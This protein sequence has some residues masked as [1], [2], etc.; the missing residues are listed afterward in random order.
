MKRFL[1]IFLVCLMLLP[2]LSAC[3]GKENGN[4]TNETATTPE[5]DNATTVAETETEIPEDLY[6][7][8][9]DMTALDY[10][11]A[12]VRILQIT[13]KSDE[14][15]FNQG[16]S[17]TMANA[18]YSRNKL[19]E[20]ELGIRFEYVSVNSTSSSPQVLNNAVRNNVTADETT[21]FHIV[22]QPS[23]Y[24]VELIL[25]GLYLDVNQIEDNYID[26]TRKY[27]SSGFM[28]AST[29]NNR[30][31]FLVGELCTSVL[32]EMEVVFVN[33]QLAA[34]YYDD[35]DLHEL[36]Y[37]KE[38]TYEKMLEL[39]AEVGNGSESGIWGMT[40]DVNSLSIDGMLGALG[41]TTVYIGENDLP[42]V[43]INNEQNI[44]I[45][46]KLRELY[47]NNQAVNNAGGRAIKNFTEQKAVFTMN[48][49]KN[50]ENLYKSD[51][52][53]TLIP[54]P[55]YNE[56]QDDYVVTA[57]DEYSSI[58]I[59]ANVTNPSMYSA[60]VED[61]CYRSHDTTY[62]A[63]YEKTY[64]S[65]YAQTLKNREMFNYMFEHLN[66]TLGGVYS[67]VLGQC[68]NMPRY[69]IYPE[70]NKYP[71]ANSNRLGSIPS[72]FINLEATAKEKLTAFIE[73][74]YAE[75][76]ES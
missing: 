19:V 22:S 54:M 68:K 15:D 67:Y 71:D 26:L 9:R 23:Y 37:D 17:E 30:S 39:I 5:N 24:T 1:I 48:M 25:E 18:V 31:Y 27:W 72:M 55:L 69:L 14:F 42:Q 12:T 74:F 8:S 7:P 58:A 41:M 34:D 45:V 46:T 70:T 40:L 76:E 13:T 61:L 36:V 2:V 38:W 35:L 21:M 28:E 49:L 52:K 53:Y 59:C 60:A 62:N 43:D 33:D 16:S 56:E 3:G 73:F 50:A 47:W 44:D 65:R 66:F 51:V 64:G 32:D 6:A 4:E 11:D 10:D 29:V 75:D 20:K 63:K 57:H